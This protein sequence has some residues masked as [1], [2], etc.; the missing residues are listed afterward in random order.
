MLKNCAQ[1]VPKI[2]QEYQNVSKNIE[3]NRNSRVFKNGLFAAYII[4]FLSVSLF[5]RFLHTGEVNG[6]RVIRGLGNKNKIL[7]GLSI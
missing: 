5:R 2:G 7:R 4:Y 3:I 6:V 1:F